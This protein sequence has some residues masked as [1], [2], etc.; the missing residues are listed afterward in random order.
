MSSGSEQ[1]RFSWNG[2]ILF[3]FDSLES[4]TSKES[5]T[6]L[7][8]R[9]QRLDHLCYEEPMSRMRQSSP[10]GLLR[11]GLLWLRNRL[12]QVWRDSEI[13]LT[14]LLGSINSFKA[15]IYWIDSLMICSSLIWSWRHRH[16]WLSQRQG[17]DRANWLTPTRSLYRPWLSVCLHYRYRTHH[18]L[19]Y[20]PTFIILCST[21]HKYD[22]LRGLFHRS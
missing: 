14:W 2:I 21:S 17:A 10:K 6:S 8:R 1:S 15:I 20:S 11:L 19:L 4:N 16:R 22:I 7:D 13:M 5:T 18:R 12:R 9:F 3:F